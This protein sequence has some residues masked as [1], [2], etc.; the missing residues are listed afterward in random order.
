MQ[1]D[2][3]L[4]LGLTP[5]QG[6]MLSVIADSPEPPSLLMLSRADEGMSRSGRV[7]ISLT[8]ALL[9]AAYR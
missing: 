2:R 4:P 6:R 8:A 1:A 7:Q 5:A 9:D 3:F